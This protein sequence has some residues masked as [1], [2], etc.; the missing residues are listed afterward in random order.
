MNIK[1]KYI[2][3]LL[4]V[5]SISLITLILVRMNLKGSNEPGYNSIVYKIDNGYGY[6]ITYNGKILIKQDYI[7][8]IYG[9]QAF[10][11][12]DD[13]LDV[14]NL[15]KEKLSKNKNPKISLFELKELEI[16]LNCLH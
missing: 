11:S 5:F 10:C 2:I 4:F 8:A 13:A 7:P 14:S 9:S 3:Y 12:Y 1:K 15:V 6:S 16:S